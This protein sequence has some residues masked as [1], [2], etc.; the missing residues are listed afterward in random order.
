MLFRRAEGLGLR[1]QTLDA[2]EH[3]FSVRRERF[4]ETP[5]PGDVVRHVVDHLR[6]QGEDDEARLEAGLL[7]GILQR[8]A[9]QL[10]VPDE[11]SAQLLDLR[12]V[13]RAQQHLSEQLIGV[14]RN[15]REQLVERVGG[16][17]LLSSRRLRL[18]GLGLRGLGV[19]IGRARAQS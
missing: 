9:R 11:P 10:G 16:H 1:A 15:G 12:R 17:R 6:K 5:R 3:P 2:V 19:G 8:R 14:E 4:A 13:A 18:R 7:G